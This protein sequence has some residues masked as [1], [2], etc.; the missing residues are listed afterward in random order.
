MAPRAVLLRVGI[1]AK[2]SFDGE[3]SGEFAC[4]P[5]G[6]LTSAAV[7]VARGLGPSSSVSGGVLNRDS[8]SLEAV[9]VVGPMC[10]VL[11]A[12]IKYTR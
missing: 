2:G 7:R 4:S 12:F 1:D 3:G 5:T 9:L 11:S 6:W 10:V 8:K